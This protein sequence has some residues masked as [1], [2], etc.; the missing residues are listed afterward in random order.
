MFPVQKFRFYLGKYPE[1]HDK[2]GITKHFEHSLFWLIIIT[3]MTKFTLF[4]NVYEIRDNSLE[5]E[6]LIYCSVSKYDHSELTELKSTF[7]RCVLL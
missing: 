3:T 6:S 5:V 1:F 7:G 2:I 4:Q